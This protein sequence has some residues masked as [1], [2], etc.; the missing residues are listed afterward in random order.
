MEQQAIKQASRVSAPR[1]LELLFLLSLVVSCSFALVYSQHVNFFLLLVFA[2]CFL[3]SLLLL[4][5]FT[6]NGIRR[7]M[8]RVGLTQRGT[9]LFSLFTFTYCFDC[10]CVHCA[11]VR[12]WCWKLMGWDW[13]FKLFLF[14]L[15]RLV[16]FVL[17][18][19]GWVG[20]GWVAGDQVYGWFGW[21]RGLF[22]FFPSFVFVFLLVWSGTTGAASKLNRDCHWNMNKIATAAT[23]TVVVDMW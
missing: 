17:W 12:A 5:L 9:C 11:C 20:L 4:L 2:L 22:P 16:R 1:R 8:N 18:G 6:T 23:A 3:Y 10:C 15:C 13:G 21:T 7:W 14:L 19:L